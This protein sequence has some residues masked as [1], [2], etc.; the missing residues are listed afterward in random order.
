MKKILSASFL[1][2]FFSQTSFSQQWGGKFEQLGNTLPSPNSY[3]TG[4]GAPGV[5]YWQQRADYNIEV[6]IN[7]NTQVLTG[8]E[9]ITYYNQ[10][11]DQ[12]RYLWVQLDQ[13]VRAKGNLNDQTGNSAIQDSVPAKFFESQLGE[14][15]YDGGYKI[16]KVADSQGKALPHTIN[17]TMMR[18]DLPKPLD[19]GQQVSF[20]IEWSYN[21]YDRM[22]IS[23]RGGY[24]YFPEDG[25]YAYTCTQWFPRMAVYDDYEGWQNK[26]FIGRGEFALVFGNYE[27]EIT[28]PADHI[29]AA[30]GELQNA[31][32]VLSKTQIERFEKARKTFDA[33]VFIVTQQEAEKNEK[34]RSKKKSTWKFKATNVRDFAFTSSR[35]Y[36]WDAQAVK[37]PTTTPLAMSFYPKEGNPLWA[38]ESTKAIKNTLEVYSART[39]DYPY[40]VAISVHAA[41]QGMEYPMICFNYGRPRNG[42]VTRRLVDGMVSV[43]VHEVGHNYF[44]MI[45]NSDERQ[46]TWMDEGLNTFLERETKLE[47]YP[48]LNHLW[49]SPKGMLPYMKM[50]KSKIRPIM[51]NS[52]QVKQFGYNAYGKPSAALTLLRETVMGPELFDKAFKEYATR[53]MF[54]HPKPADFFRTME[55][56]SGMDLDWFWRGWFYTVDHVDVALDEVKWFKMRKETPD[57][58]N[59]GKNVQ[60]GDLSSSTAKGEKASDFGAGPEPFS[61]T[62]TEARYYGEFKNRVNDK[63]IAAK[64]DDKNFYQLKFKNE[65]GLVSPLIIE[66]TF[67]DGSKQLEHIPAEIWRYNE[68]EV[69]KVFAFEKQVSNIMLDPNEKTADTNPEDNVF[70]RQMVKSRFDEFK[71]K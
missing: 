7:D 42:K 67:T 38:D 15:D 21:M 5:N 43:I 47:R 56:A 18:I 26:Q 55:D 28:V 11:P 68:K 57:V 46:W 53:W 30:T 70:P 51:T 37:L 6:E 61:L 50:E 71:S 4:S 69:T 44:P 58:E 32:Q 3:R 25:N 54:K 9:T 12:L 64:F 33:P 10:S 41:N 24:E 62:D 60:Q 63:A 36:I 13:N 16:T 29:V 34:S 17:R 27:V 65:G 39:F 8:N 59:K 19:P 35:K 40:P 45:V 52:E 20:T 48:D 1:L 14:L 2:I 31:K 23:G 22:Q 49:G 66:F